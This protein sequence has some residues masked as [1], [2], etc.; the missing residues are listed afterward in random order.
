MVDYGGRGVK[1]LVACFC[2]SNTDTQ[3]ISG[4]SRTLVIDVVGSGSK[5]KVS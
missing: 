4:P 2:F 5:E 1:H 3:A